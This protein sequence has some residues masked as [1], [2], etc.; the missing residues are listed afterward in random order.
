MDDIDVTLFNAVVME[1]YLAHL[2][3]APIAY[4]ESLRSLAEAMTAYHFV[5][6]RDIHAAFM[7][8]AQRQRRTA[9]REHLRQYHMEP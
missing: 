8:D 7:T 2:R 4:V 3:G 1:A 9:Y 6:K 5:E